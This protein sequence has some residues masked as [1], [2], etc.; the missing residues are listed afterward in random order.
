MHSVDDDHHHGDRAGVDNELDV[1]DIDVAE[2]FVDVLVV[3]DDIVALILLNLSLNLNLNLKLAA[4]P[5][6][7]Q[8]PGLLA[9]ALIASRRAHVVEQRVLDHQARVAQEEVQ[10]HLRERAELVQPGVLV[11][12]AG[13]GAV[14]GAEFLYR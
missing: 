3:N 11:C 2:L 6:D 8:R 10:G 4:D 9:E 12:A 5:A 1:H 7:A 13:V 14:G